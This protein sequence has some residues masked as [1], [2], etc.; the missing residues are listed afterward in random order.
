[1]SKADEIWKP[2]KDYENEYEISNYGEVK[3]LARNTTKGKILKS[4]LQNGY[5][6]VML[7]KNNKKRWYSIHRLVAETFIL[8]SENKPQ[9]N[10]KDGNKLNNHVDNLEWCTASENIVHSIN[11]KLRTI[12][13]GGQ[14]KLSKKVY[15]FNLD[16]EVVKIWDSLNDIHRELGISAGNISNCCNGKKKSIKGFVWRYVNE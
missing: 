2:I 4:F 10:H 9:I 8:N 12:K 5:L 16:G 7:S 3:S 15:Q 13:N 6:R 1:M 14:H 11:N